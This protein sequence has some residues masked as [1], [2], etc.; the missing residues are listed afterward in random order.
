MPAAGATV[1]AM[2]SCCLQH[3]PH[4][5]LKGALYKRTAKVPSAPSPVCSLFLFIILIILD[6]VPWII[7][8][9]WPGVRGRRPRF[10]II[11]III[12]HHHHRHHHHH[13]S[14]SSSPIRHHQSTSFIIVISKTYHHRSAFIII[15]Y[16]SP[17]IIHHLGFALILFW[18]RFYLPL[19][20]RVPIVGEYFMPFISYLLYQH[21]CPLL[22][23]FIYAIYILLYNKFMTALLLS[24]VMGRPIHVEQ[25]NNPS[26]F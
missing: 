18:G 3:T 2:T 8:W 11:I 12:H 13:P 5:V 25:N 23:L 26:K 6:Q 20:Y 10:I 14:S 16:H 21:L 17:S 15:I 24:G 4:V 7:L 19:P 9:Q 22:F 1:S